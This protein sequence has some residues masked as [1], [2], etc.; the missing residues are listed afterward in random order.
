MLAWQMIITECQIACIHLWSN[1]FW[2]HWIEELNLPLILSIWFFLHHYHLLIC[3]Q[4]IMSLSGIFLKPFFPSQINLIF[5]HM[6]RDISRIQY[7]SLLTFL[8]NLP[9]LS[10]KFWTGLIHFYYL[11][12]SLPWI[13]L[14]VLALSWLHEFSRSLQLQCYR[15]FTAATNTHIIVI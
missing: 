14:T 13:S 12:L 6:S 11:H 7:A 4:L 8:E 15:N 1:P 5:I 9:N 10:Y 3:Q 2:N